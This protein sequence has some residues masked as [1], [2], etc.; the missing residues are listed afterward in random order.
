MEE[1]MEK[2]SQLIPSLHVS[3]GTSQPYGI[4]PQFSFWEFWSHEIWVLESCRVILLFII[5]TGPPWSWEGMINNHVGTTSIKK[6]CPRQTKLYGHPTFACFIRRVIWCSFGDYVL[7]VDLL[8]LNS[9]SVIY[10]LCDLSDL[11]FFY[12]ISLCLSYLINKM[13]ASLDGRGVWGGMYIYGWVT[14]HA[15]KLLQHC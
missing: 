1:Q 10:N 9:N 8:G 6:H 2:W 7:Q 11:W 13:V 4:K 12:L 5:K 3:M 15:T 14:S